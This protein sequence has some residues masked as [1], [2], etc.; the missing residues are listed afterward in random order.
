[1]T[2]EGRRVFLANAENIRVNMADSTAYLVIM[3]LLR[4]RTTY[5]RAI[6]RFPTSTTVFSIIDT[7]RRNWGIMQ[8]DPR[9]FFA[10]SKFVSNV[11]S[12][13]NG[14]E[15]D[16][17]L[18]PPGALSYFQHVPT[19]NT[20]YARAGPAA[21]ENVYGRG[22]SAAGPTMTELRPFLIVDETQRPMV[23]EE[24]TGGF[25]LALDT[26][27]P[28]VAGN[29]ALR[30]TSTAR[31][32]ALLDADH[33]TISTITLLEMVR[34]CGRFA[35]N[36]RL[37]PHHAKL[38]EELNRGGVEVRRSRLEVGG[39][40]VHHHPDMFLRYDD[41]AGWGV[42]ATFGDMQTISAEQ[43]RMLAV[44]TLRNERLAGKAREAPTEK[45]AL[46]EIVAEYRDAP[47]SREQLEAWIKEDRPLPVTF[48]LVRP[49]CSYDMGACIWANNGAGVAPYSH[50]AANVG[51]D[52]ETGRLVATFTFYHDAAVLQQSGV[53]VLE[54]LVGVRYNGGE[55]LQFFPADFTVGDE[56]NGSSM[57]CFMMPYANTREQLKIGNHLDVTGGYNM[58]HFMRY[59][60]DQP[61]DVRDGDPWHYPS[62]LYYSTLH[63]FYRLHEGNHRNEWDD[64]YAARGRNTICHTW[65]LFYASYTLL[66]WATSPRSWVG[67]FGFTNDICRERYIQ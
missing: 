13:E 39:G 21:L 56:T 62:A 19:D 6:T 36:G 35:A 7:L 43:W 34:H 28:Q 65:I 59:L 46:D 15:P 10:L 55:G 40:G 41:G 67:F 24:Q 31:S 25:V 58:D 30:Y 33:N 16:H 50:E 52:A 2:E 23:R 27:L 32:V 61:T 12:L 53:D 47:V 51:K 37:D 17:V 9:G 45:D 44:A 1:M 22:Q 11:M 8:K 63:R 66:D 29:S 3:A 38:A 20:D 42:V 14:R 5:R 64:F 48:A 57:F 4:S 49:W 54:S 60:R 26:V 18:L